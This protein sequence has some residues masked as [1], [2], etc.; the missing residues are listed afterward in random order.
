MTAIAAAV[1]AMWERAIMKYIGNPDGAP[2]YIRVKQ[3]SAH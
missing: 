3:Q 1:S 2:L